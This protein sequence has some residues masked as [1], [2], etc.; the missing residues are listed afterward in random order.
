MSTN[1]GTATR[2]KESSPDVIESTIRTLDEPVKRT[3]GISLF[4]VLTLGAIGASVALFIAGRKD[5]AIFIGLWPP[6]FQALKAASEGKQ[7]GE[8]GR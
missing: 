3:A 2:S 4:H 6:T 5:L 8:R 7:A 1:V